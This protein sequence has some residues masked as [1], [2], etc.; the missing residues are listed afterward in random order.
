M[1]VARLVL[2]V[3]RAQHHAV[4]GA[5]LLVGGGGGQTAACLF[6]VSGLDADGL[7][8]GHA[9]HIPVA[10]QGVGAVENPGLRDHVGGLQGV[11]GGGDDFAEN[12]VLHSG[13]SHEVDVIGGGVVVGIVETM[14]V[15]KVSA[16][17]A[18]VFRSLIHALHKGLFRAAQGFG[19]NVTGLIARRHQIAVQQLLDGEHFALHNAGGG[20]ALG[21]GH[22]LLGGCYLGLQGELSGVNGPEDHQGGHDL[23]DRGGVAFFVGVV[24]IQDLVVVPVHHNGGGAVGLRVVQSEGGR[25]TQREG[26]NKSCGQSRSAANVFFHRILQSS[27]L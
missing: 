8:V 19:Q 13:G 17:H 20:A 6:G 14:G 7:G 1:P 4:E 11:G 18:Q 27:M 12:L 21:Q 25:Q 24:V 2:G 22:R 10:N 5:A 16:C 15:G 3:F 23:G 9:G 26:E